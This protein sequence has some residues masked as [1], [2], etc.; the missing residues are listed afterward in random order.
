[1]YVSFILDLTIDKYIY[2]LYNSQ[3]II[4]ILLGINNYL[5]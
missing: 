2:I 3:Y 4:Y 5:Y 1:M